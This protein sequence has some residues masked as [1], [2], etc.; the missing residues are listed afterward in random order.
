MNVHAF[1][2]FF[3]ALPSMLTSAVIWLALAPIF[4][5]LGAIASVSERLADKKEK[6]KLRHEKYLK[7]KEQI[8]KRD[9]LFLTDFEYLS[10]Q[11]KREDKDENR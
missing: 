7:L 10:S 4:L 3:I 2:L 1:W 5:V 11:G 9:D 6:E 8:V